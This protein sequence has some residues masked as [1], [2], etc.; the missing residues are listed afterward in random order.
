MKH[1]LSPGFVVV[2]PVTFLDDLLQFFRRTTI[3]LHLSG[4][5]EDLHLCFGT[6]VIE[7]IG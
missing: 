3:S 6:R 2:C 4:I 1:R 5:K 7:G